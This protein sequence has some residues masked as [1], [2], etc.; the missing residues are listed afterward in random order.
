MPSARDNRSWESRTPG[1]KGFYSRAA[2]LDDLITS[3]LEKKRKS[4]EKIAGIGAET[5]INVAKIG[6]STRL[7]EAAMGQEGETARMRLVQAGNAILEGLRGSNEMARQKFASSEAMKRL[8]AAA[9]EQRA[10]LGKKAELD[11]EAY[12]SLLEEQLANRRKK[13]G[14]SFEEE[15]EEGFDL[16]EFIN[17][18]ED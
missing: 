14:Y 6:S 16:T 13:G 8:R 7:K 15:D 4:S 17:I 12:S 2:D 1:I 5:D 9:T 3:D 11:K 18:P 10:T